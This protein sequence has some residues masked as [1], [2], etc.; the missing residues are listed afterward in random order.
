MHGGATARSKKKK[1]AG[2]PPADNTKW[3]QQE[4]TERGT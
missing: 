3:E 1:T 4:H 2:E